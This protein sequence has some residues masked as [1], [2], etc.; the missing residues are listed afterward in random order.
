MNERNGYI[1]IDFETTGLCFSTLEVLQVSVINDKG[2]TLLH[3]YCR[4]KHTDS[5]EDAEAIHGISP[6][7][8][9]GCPTFREG[10]LPKLLE[11]I[12]GVSA[13]IAYNADFER[14]VLR[15]AYG[16]DPVVAF[17]DPML[18]FA[19]VYGEWTDYFQD[20]RWQKLETAASYYNYEFKAHDALEDVK[21]T[22]FVFEKMIEAGVVPIMV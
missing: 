19:P 3:G 16:V 7:M 5:W 12:E 8:V 9:A 18:M 4:P 17:I 14:N 21:A 6:E 10:Y 2:E 13:V 15:Y 1:V 22:R 20:Y 11:L